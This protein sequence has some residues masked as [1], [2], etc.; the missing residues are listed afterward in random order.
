MVNFSLFL[1]VC[2]CEREGE[3]EWEGHLLLLQ[4]ENP[5]PPACQSAAGDVAAR[6]T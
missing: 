6:I 5:N 2:V 3:S 1:G 4:A